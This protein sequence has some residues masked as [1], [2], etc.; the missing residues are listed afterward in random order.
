MVMFFPGSQIVQDRSS[1]GN[2]ISS[3]DNQQDFCVI[4]TNLTGQNVYFSFERSSTTEDTDDID[5]TSNVYLIFSMGSYTTTFNPQDHFFR[6]S[7]ETDVNLIQCTSSKKK[8]I[9]KRSIF[10][11]K[12]SKLFDE[13]LF[14]NIVFLFTRGSNRCWTVCLF[15]IVFMYIR[16]DDEFGCINNEFIGICTY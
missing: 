2:A 10:S 9:K 15:S 5:L 8:Y 11:S 4:Q 3:I 1:R 13:K 7:L 6:K 14:Y 16:I 12:F